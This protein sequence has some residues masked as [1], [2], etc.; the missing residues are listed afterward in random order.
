MSNKNK[1]YN[2]NHFFNKDLNEPKNEKDY[3]KLSN[4]EK[5][6]YNKLLAIL[7]LKLNKIHKKN[8]NNN[9]WDKILG[10]F[11]LFHI[12]ACNRFFNSDITNSHCLELQKTFL[13]THTPLSGISSSM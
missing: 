13:C 6:K 3:I 7:T 4:F 8:Y 11:I 5:K 10:Y 9:Y 12:S 1:I 2:L